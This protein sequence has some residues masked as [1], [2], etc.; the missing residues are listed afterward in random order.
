MCSCLAPEGKTLLEALIPSTYAYWR[1]LADDSDERYE[2]E[3]Q[4]VALQALQALEGHYPGITADVEMT[5]VAT[6]LTFERYTGNWQGSYGGWLITT[7]NIG[8]I[9][10]GKTLPRTLPGLADFHMIG[11]WVMP[12]GGL[13]SGSMT[14]RMVIQ[15]L[16]KLD[17]KKFTTS[18]PAEALL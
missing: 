11:Q 7:D 2:A 1:A 10:S 15:D 17:G 18:L 14:G 4:Q 8:Q 6:P 3:K 13:P 5:D 12:G 9:F 16:C